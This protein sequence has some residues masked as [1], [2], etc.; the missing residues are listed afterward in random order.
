V[1]YSTPSHSP[2]DDPR[3]RLVAPFGA[4]ID[5]KH[6]P[7]VH[8]AGVERFAPNADPS[9]K[10]CSRFY[11]LCSG[12]E[13][14]DHQAEIRVL[15]GEPWQPD[16]VDLPDVSLTGLSHSA[17]I[18]VDPD[19]IASDDEKAAALRM[20]E[21][22][23]RRLAEWPSGGRQVRAYGTARYVGHLVASV[24]LAER[25][26]ANALWDAV[27]GEAGNGVGNEREADVRRALRR[28]LNRGVADGAY[29][30]TAIEDFDD[31]GDGF[32]NDEFEPVEQ[33][34]GWGER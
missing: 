1:C 25:T 6:W 31:F 5:A 28:G 20:L 14:R 27:A 18:G 22:T 29:D 9:C 13:E 23:C 26:A 10:D 33:R 16:D 12:P 3:W 4:E 34:R 8:A 24:A 15:D 11:F 7:S 30:F 17:L 2:P 19:R 21:S 32:D